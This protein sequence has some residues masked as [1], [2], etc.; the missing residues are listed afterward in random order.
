MSEGDVERLYR[1]LSDL[2]DEVHGYRS[3]LNGRLRKLEVANASRTGAENQ[4]NMSNARI[5]VWA[6]IIIAGISAGTTIL[7]RITEAM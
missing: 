3:D 1:M 2:R 7:L 5:A 6:G 4:K